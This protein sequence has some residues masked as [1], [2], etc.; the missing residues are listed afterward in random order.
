MANYTQLKN[1]IDSKIN[2][3]GKQAITGAILNETLKSMVDAMA[4][5]GD[6]V[7]KNASDIKAINTTV[8]TVNSNL[9]TS[10]E[11]INKNVADG[12]NTIN[13]GINNEIRP[14]IEKNSKD[15]QNLNATV[16]AVNS[17]LVAS[18]EAINKNVADGFNTINGGIDNEIRPEIIKNASAITVMEEKVASA[19]SI[20]VVDGKEVV[21]LPKNTQIM[22]TLDDGIYA[23]ASVRDY[24][25]GITQ[26]EIGSASLHLCLNTKDDI[27]VDTPDGQ[28]VLAFVDDIPEIPEVDLSPYL[29]ASA[30]SELY[31]SKGD[32]ALKSEIPST[33]GLAAESA[34]TKL[35]GDVDYIGNTLIPEMNT[36]TANALNGKVDWDETKSV[37]SLPANGSISAMRGVPEEGTQPEGGNMICQR[38]YDSGASYVTEVGT[39]KNHLTMNSTDRPTVDMNGES[40]SIAFE[41]DLPRL[42]NFP[43]RTLSD[44]IYT[45]EEILAWFGV[46]D[47]PGLK[48]LMASGPMSY[49]RYGI[50]LTYKP[51]YYRF[52]INYMAFA[53]D[54]QIVLIALGLNTNNDKACKYTITMNLDGTILEGNCNIKIDIL[55]LEA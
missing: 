27:T 3:N 12:F 15:I 42:V 39:V 20:S 54:T 17:N 25:S 22:G 55:E 43:L 26:T 14:A 8:A 51:M 32:Y 1:Q 11:A 37:I 41:T 44:K 28:K 19:L 5:D 49:L 53:S 47:V 33:D 2:T 7:E 24:G 35:A 40:A 6:A 36:N 31:Q 48:Q 52:P 29:M 21:S 46:E 4:S 16:A 34:V 45:Q 30:A 50:T 10:V 18:V 23:L 38:T 13:G 9:V